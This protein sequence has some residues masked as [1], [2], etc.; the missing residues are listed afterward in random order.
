MK[1]FQALLVALAVCP[2]LS[3]AQVEPALFGG[4][5]WRNV[6]PERGGR[7][8]ACSGV[9]G[10]PEEF[11]MGTC[12]G[13]LW[14][15]TNSGED[16]APVS[17]GWFG[18]GVVGAIAVAPSQPQT[19]YVGTGE[20]DL[21]G[22]VSHG[23]GVYR[24]DDSGKTWR[25]I[26]LKDSQ[27]VSRIVVHPKDPETAWVAVLGHV[28]GPH[29]ERGVFKTTDGGKSWKRTLFVNDRAGAVHIA[30][31]PHDVNV[32]YAATWDG[33]R[34]PWSL[35]SGGPNSKLWKSVDGG[36]TWSDLSQNK[37]MPSGPLGK[38][39]VSPSPAKK[40]RVYAI[41][42]AA[43]GGVFVS[44]DAG[45]SWERVDSGRDRR[46][47]AFYYTHIYAHPTEADTVYVLNVA[48]F[49][50]TNGGK[51]FRTFMAGHSDNHDIWVNPSDPNRMAVSNDGGTAVSVNGGSS[52]TDQDYATAQIY[53]VSTDNAIPY[54][55]LGAQQDNSTIRIASRNRSARI[56]K[57]DWTST[58]GGES[59]FVVAKPDNPDIVLGGSYGGD[60]SMLDHARNI[61]RSI[62]PWPDNPMGSGAG[63]NRERFQW[64]FPIVFSP[65]NPNVVYTC[66]QHV[67]R[68]EDLGGSWTRISPDLTRAEPSTLV[69]SGGPITKDNTSVE[70]YATVFSLAESTLEPGLLWAGSDDGRV[71]VTRDGG[72]K[73]TEITPPNLGDWSLV[74]MVE[75]SPH[76][77][78][79]C[80]LAIDRHEV[81]DYAP[82]IYKT[83]DYGK[84]W[85]RLDAGI[86]DGA[87][88]RAVREDPEAPG[89]LYC[90][91]EVGVFVSLDGG[92]AWQK[93]DNN[94]PVVP[95][96]DLVV[97]EGDLIAA[98]H[99]RSFYVLD[100]L[101]PL[102]QAA[103][104]K[105]AGKAH[106][107][108]PDPGSTL[109]WGP[110]TQGVGANPA[111][112]IVLD[113]VLFAKAEQAEI[114]VTDGD[115]VQVGRTRA[116]TGPGHGR[117]TV[118]LSYPGFRG[119]PGMVF[120]AAGSRPIKAPP[121]TY[122]ATLVV[123]GE[124]ISVP[125]EV[126]GDPR[127]PSSSSDLKAQFALSMALVE[128][129]NQANGMV[130]KL[131]DLVGMLQAQKAAAPAAAAKV[132]PFI[133]K[134]EEASNVIYQSKSV[135]GQDPLNYPIR[136]NNK[137]AAL[138]GIVQSGEWAPT[139]Q[140]YEVYEDLS[141]Q[142]KAALADCEALL[143]SELDEVNKAIVAAGGK[144]V[145]VPVGG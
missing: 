48:C 133:Q 86:P 16:W 53:H 76:A 82:Y 120:W 124:E 104:V 89:V 87:F 95:I 15:T 131:R 109:T 2:V 79:T 83:T 70:Y 85:G 54:R 58:A 81:D 52:W 63:D 78:G 80:Y 37:G 142:L 4:L 46:Q 106:F 136:L 11:Y 77:A 12:G 14:K 100:R 7:S 39:G 90:G 9:P 47:R 25:H 17:D 19:V 71:H 139:R 29:P 64:T 144:A 45:T 72:N 94:M 111:S 91:T 50:S 65:H 108:R 33:W 34:T 56:G 137:L 59:G 132:D 31:D 134:V 55:I 115:G 20:R 3:S 73:W 41:V 99:G 42:E 68:S 69:S 96:H 127:Y 116:E 21:R 125:L 62:D 122:K 145:A 88:V 40:G 138:I 129:V 23:D 35:N 113:Y 26:G 43:E 114:V 97:K 119:F 57:D 84:T 22:N 44:E 105:K 67:W 18:T 112:G 5:K 60:L 130:V 10:S 1:A 101:S 141:A 61:S 140:S 8:V 102:R 13:G 98:S 36:E 28:Y 143:G 118:R 51:S 74:S 123:D 49:K 128:K 93:L 126:R 6:G 135:S 38:I 66:S 32:L 107:Y 103:G 30:L 92:K 117:S 75:P 121:G 110:A 27:T 24:T